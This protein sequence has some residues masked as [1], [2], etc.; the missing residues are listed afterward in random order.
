M[1]ILE[2]VLTKF[3][4]DLGTGGL[5]DGNQP[6]QGSGLQGGGSDNKLI[7]NNT[8]DSTGGLSDSGA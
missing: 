8:G 5:G 7:A 2:V 3:L 4:T 6:G 1:L